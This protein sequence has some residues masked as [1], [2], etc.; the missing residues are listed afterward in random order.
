VQKGK[1]WEFNL[2]Q[3]RISSIFNEITK[4]EDCPLQRAIS[5]LEF[6]KSNEI[7]PEN[8]MSNMTKM[9]KLYQEFSEMLD[10]KENGKINLYSLHRIP[11]C[12][13]CLI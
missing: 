12:K 10:F 3:K 7:L 11:F 5:R 13:V 2:F 4:E 8:L 1:D 6:L 9:F